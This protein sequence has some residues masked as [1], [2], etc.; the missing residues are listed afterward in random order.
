VGCRKFN[1]KRRRFMKTIFT[2]QILKRLFFLLIGVAGLTLHAHAQATNSGFETGNL[3]GWTSAGT[4]SVVA[5]YTGTSKYGGG[6]WTVAPAGAYMART[7]PIEGMANPSIAD[8]E[9]NLGLTAGALTASNSGVFKAATNFGT[10]TQSVK[11]NAGQTITL[12]WNFVSQDYYPYNDG[13]LATMTGP[14]YQNIKLLAVTSNAYGDATTI[15]T[16]DFGSTDWHAVTFTAGAAGVYKVGFASFNYYDNIVNPL[17]FSDNAPGGTSAPGQPIVS[18]SAVTLTSATTAA[19]GGNVTAD[20]GSSVTAR[21]V[22][23]GTSTQPTTADN[24]TVDGIGTGKFTSNITG[25]TPNVTYYVRAYA[26]NIAGTVYGAQ[27]TLEADNEAPVI[28]TNGDKNVFTDANACGAVVTVNATATDNV[29]VGSPMGTR[30]DGQA[31][32][33][34]YPVGVTTITWTVSDANNNAAIPVIQTVTVTDKELPTIKAPVAVT[35]STDA[36]QCSASNVV[37]GTPTTADNCTVTKVSSNAPAAFG[38][39]TTVVTW[40]VT[41]ASGNV[42]T[43]TQLVTVKDVTAP[44]VVTRNVTVSLAGGLATLMAADVNGGSSDNCSGTLTYSVSPS[45][46]NCANTGP[47]TVTLT[48]TDA[49]GNK[50]TGTA[51][52]TVLGGTPTPTITVTPANGTY[53]GGTATTLYLGYGSPSVTLTASGGTSYQWSPTTGLSNATS[54]NPVFTA[55]QAGK[56]TYTVTATSGSGCTGTA[57]VTLTVIDARCGSGNSG[58][59]DKVLVCHKGNTIC[60]NAGDVADHLNHGDPLGTCTATS[61]TAS[62]VASGADRE[63]SASLEAYPNPFTNSTTLRFRAAQAGSVQLQVYN[64][65]GQLVATLYNGPVKSGE[66]L[67]RTLDGAGLSTGL[68][69]CR[70][71]TEGQTLTQRVVLTK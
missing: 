67:E 23:W 54:A 34:S 9:A 48:V 22:C 44:T 62:L 30:S 36:G 53:T 64:A 26:T 6:N 42:A 60:I 70:F 40:T 45:T 2:T 56:F 12:Y 33:A 7:E 29:S 41:D 38:S 25:L 65:M 58:K 55:T 18:T 61:Q 20:G 10:L 39:G 3:T 37:L 47:N 63:A 11:L 46:F 71:A 21:G 14:S 27:E 17:M 69:T 59:L 28:S 35:V 31:L 52:V 1:C 50:S 16:G 66:L 5:G 4:V 32:T 13:V 8:A 24:Y 68:Y 15:V 49:S 19:T 51:T 43:T 57:S